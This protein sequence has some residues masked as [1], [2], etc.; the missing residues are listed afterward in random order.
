MHC[1]VSTMCFYVLLFVL[2]YVLFVCKCVLLPPGTNPI[3]V[4]Y[5]ITYTISYLISLRIQKYWFVADTYATDRQTGTAFHP[6]PG[7]KRS[8]QLHKMYQSRCTAKN[9]WWWAERL[10]ETCRV[11][12]PIKLEFSASVGII[13]KETFHEFTSKLFEVH[14]QYKILCIYY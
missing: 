3:A 13:H 9:S 7:S 10:P 8:L 1:F 12:V 14:F 2:F 11:V 4:K 5:I 6:A